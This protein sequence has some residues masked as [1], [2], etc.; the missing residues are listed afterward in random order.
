MQRLTDINAHVR[1]RGDFG[2]DDTF[3]QVEFQGL[4]PIGSPELT[5]P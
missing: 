5:C 1:R 4:E 3:L 2:D